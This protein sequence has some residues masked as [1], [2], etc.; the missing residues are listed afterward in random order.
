MKKLK[1]FG[2]SPGIGIGKAEKIISDTFSVYEGKKIHSSKVEEEIKRFYDG[3]KRTQ[4]EILKIKQA[5]E[6]LAGKEYSEIF[7]FHISILQDKNLIE[8]IEKIIKEEK[9]SAESALKKFVIN[10]NRDI[11]ESKFLKERKKELL[12]IFE[13][14]LINLTNK[15]E[16]I[17]LL[18][19]KI[20][21]ANDLSPTQTVSI[22]KK[23]IKGFVTSIGTETSH[24]V[25]IAK[26]LEIPAVVGVENAM[27][28]IKE[29]DTLLID[30]YEGIVIVNPTPSEIEK[31]KLKEKKIAQIKKKIY[32]LKNLET[33]TLDK[34]KVELYANIELPEEI[35]SVIKYGA[36]GI[37]LFRT[38]YL[39]LK[40][41]DLPSEEEQFL[42]YMK[43]IEKM[44]KKPIII[45]TIDVGGDKFISSF[46]GP[47]E[48][49]SFLGLRGIRFCLVKKEIFLT[50][51]KAILRASYY[52]NLKIMFP[53][54]TTKEEVIEA[55]KI[56]EIAKQELR[57]KGIKFNDNI[58]IGI[59]IE[60]PS[61]ALISDELSK[62]VNFFSIGSNDLIQYTLAIDRV[63][64]KLSYLYKPCHPSILKLIKLTIENAKKNN[65]KVGIC[66][67]MASIPEIACLLV[68]MGIDELSMAPVAIPNVKEKI[69][70][71][72]YE[73]MKEVAEKSLNFNSHEKII[74]FLKESLN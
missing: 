73:K 24:T 8:K 58:E 61:A 60:T 39:Y 4:E 65:I 29:N 51:L 41:K 55:K 10:L 46:K 71:N 33:S 74:E 47:E 11:S 54:I 38:E 22:N 7:S 9:V 43:I 30:G 13:Q 48:L 26:A 66:G 31:R 59:M 44:G 63:N 64:E 28:V 67:E 68:G 27:E 12:D 3:I 18:K 19:N 6:K 72:Y 2:A 42:S 62:E 53:M 21:V 69:I 70:K 56:V 45:R 5:T 52:G 25:I 35:E 14:I 57:E 32:I 36:E 17:K 50:Q 37:G 15:D 1:G 23:Y 49:N 40:R 20:I 34:K 16:E